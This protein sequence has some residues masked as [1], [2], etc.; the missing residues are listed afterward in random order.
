MLKSAVSSN[1]IS[2][3]TRYHTLGKADDDSSE[4][5]NIEQVIKTDEK[6]NCE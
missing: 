4:S 2:V 5:Q 6:L 3:S 1:C